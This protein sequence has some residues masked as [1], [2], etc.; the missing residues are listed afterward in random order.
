MRPAAKKTYDGA[1][2]SGWAGRF[3]GAGCLNVAVRSAS[4]VAGMSGLQ[5]GPGA[6]PKRMMTSFKD[7]SVIG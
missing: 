2:S 4:I 3:I 6:P 1:I 5:T 7:V